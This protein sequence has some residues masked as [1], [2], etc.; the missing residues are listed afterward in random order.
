VSVVPER[1]TERLLLRGWQN[2]D[3]RAFAAMNADLDVMRHFPSTLRTEQSDEMVDR[4]MQHWSERGY[5][6]W[7]VQ[8]LDN[9]EFIGFVGLH[10]PSFQA[11]FT[12]C[13]EVGWRL[14]HA[15]WGNGFAPEAALEALA[16]A[17]S[18]VSLPGDEVVSFTTAGNTNSRRVME[19]LGLRRDP[20]DDFDHPALTHWEGRRHVLYRMHRSQWA[21]QM[22]R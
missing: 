19:K 5:G 10:A 17:F 11:H 20:A 2:S 9:D 3:R 13:V 1:R 8:R 4:H 6:L 22:A 7:A 21:A 15:H 18:E 14:A 12:P 16:F